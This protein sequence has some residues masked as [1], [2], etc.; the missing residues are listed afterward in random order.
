M[1]N[2]YVLILLLAVVLATRSKIFFTFAPSYSSGLSIAGTGTIKWKLLND[3]GDKVILHLHNSLYVP[4]APM[5]L[6]IAQQMNLPS[7]GF[8]R[9][10]DL[11]FLSLVVFNEPFPT[12]RPIIFL[13]CY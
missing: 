4:D 9:K 11:V 10:T 7:D 2:P 8:H 1:N 12:I 13:F 5:H 3:S 6:L